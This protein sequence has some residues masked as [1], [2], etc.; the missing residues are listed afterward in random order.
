MQGLSGDLR[1]VGSLGRTG[2][3][4]PTGSA[5]SAPFG[6]LLPWSRCRILNGPVRRGYAIDD[7]ENEEGTRCAGA[8]VLTD[9]LHPVGAISVSGRV[10]RLG[11]RRLSEIA[12]RVVEAADAV[13]VELG[14][15]AGRSA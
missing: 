10:D 9:D 15:R 8:P 6:R 5:V 7:I 4:T 2:C 1:E 11:D 14:Y 13:S 3:Q 12:S